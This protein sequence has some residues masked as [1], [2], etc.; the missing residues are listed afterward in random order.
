MVQ[1]VSTGQRNLEAGTYTSEAWKSV[2]SQLGLWRGECE[3]RLL[4]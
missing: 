1:G 3:G 2:T 4:T